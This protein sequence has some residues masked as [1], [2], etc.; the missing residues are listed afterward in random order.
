MFEELMEHLG[1]IVASAFARK[2]S[3]AVSRP[4]L[5]L[6]LLFEFAYFRSNEKFCVS[7]IGS[8]LPVDAGESESNGHALGVCQRAFRCAVRPEQQVSVRR[9]ICA[10]AFG[11]QRIERAVY[12]DLRL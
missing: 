6:V 12:R 7:R 9:R 2:K 8:S 3:G 1:S 4:P 5:W 11:F 10:G